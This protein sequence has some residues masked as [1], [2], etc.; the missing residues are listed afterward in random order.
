MGGLFS[1][2]ESSTQDDEKVSDDDEAVLSQDVP[3]T[4]YIPD[5]NVVVKDDESPF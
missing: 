3:E 5:T 2:T 4:D 1:S